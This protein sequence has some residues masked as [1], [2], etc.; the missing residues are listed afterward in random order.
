MVE[1]YETSRFDIPDNFKNKEWYAMLLDISSI[2]KRIDPLADTC[3]ETLDDYYYSMKVYYAT[4]RDPL[5][6]AFN[7]LYHMGEI[8]T[9][10]ENVYYLI[11][12]RDDID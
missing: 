4:W 9:A 5:L 10:T 2:I 1:I 8:Y 11:K 12:N 6:L 7:V 3:I